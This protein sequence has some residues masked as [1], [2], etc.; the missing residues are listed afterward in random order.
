MNLWMIDVY[1]TLAQMALSARAI[2]RRISRC[3]SNVVRSF[4]L[5][6]HQEH[7]GLFGVLLG[8]DQTH[9]FGHVLLL[10]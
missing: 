7:D 4:T 3:F 10:L 5:S 1:L 6:L 9:C 2:W 8:P